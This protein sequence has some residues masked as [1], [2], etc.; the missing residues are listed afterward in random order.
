MLKYQVNLSILPDHPSVDHWEDEV[1]SGIFK[2]PYDIFP[3]EIIKIEGVPNFRVTGIEKD[4]MGSL[5]VIQGVTTSFAKTEED[6]QK[7]VKKY[8]VVLD[9]LI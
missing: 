1:N 2:R 6:F 9:R 7:D 3:G 5:V 8:K 4:L